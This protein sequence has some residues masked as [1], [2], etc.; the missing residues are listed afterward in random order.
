MSPHVV[1]IGCVMPSPVSQFRSKWLKLTLSG[2]PPFSS[3]SISYSAPSPHAG[4][5]QTSGH[6]PGV[7][8]NRPL[9]LNVPYWASKVSIVDSD[10]DVR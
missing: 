3:R 8:L 10:A 7:A 1:G 6:V 4:I 9:N 2:L 5:I